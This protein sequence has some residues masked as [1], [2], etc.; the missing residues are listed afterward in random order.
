MLPN[1]IVEVY[2]TAYNEDT[3]WGYIEEDWISMDYVGNITHRNSA[4]TIYAED[5]V[6][7]TTA[8]ILAELGPEYNI[9]GAYAGSYLLRTINYPDFY[10]AYNLDEPTSDP[11]ITGFEPVVCIYLFG[12]AAINEYL[13]AN[14]SKEDLDRAINNPDVLSSSTNTVYVALDNTG[15]VFQYQIE[16]RRAYISYEWYMDSGSSTNNPADSICVS[17]K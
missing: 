7:F 2:E 16:T 12:N 8:E 11:Y 1:D 17:P 14:M 15:N 3:T 10:F 13:S 4:N 6:D 9:P 5:Y